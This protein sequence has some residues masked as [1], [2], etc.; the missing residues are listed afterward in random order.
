MIQ[1]PKENLSIDRVNQKAKEKGH[2][3]EA[4][5]EHVVNWGQIRWGWSCQGW[6]QMLC[7]FLCRGLL[8]G[9]ICQNIF[10]DLLGISQIIAEE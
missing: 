4:E 9:S 3:G 1:L 5:K 10:N 2:Q 7:N 8:V 6:E